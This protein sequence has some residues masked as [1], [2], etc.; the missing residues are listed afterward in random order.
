MRNASPP[1]STDGSADSAP[2]PVSGRLRPPGGTAD[3][4]GPLAALERNLRR[5]EFHSLEWPESEGLSH[6]HREVLELTIRHGLDSHGLG[7]VLGLGQSARSGQSQRPAHLGRSGRGARLLGDTVGSQGFGM[8]ADAWREL[9]RSLAA[10]AVA[11]ASTEHCAQLAELTSG[12]SGR[13][14]GT[15][16]APLTDHVDGCTRCQHYLHTVIGTPAAPTILPFITAPRALREIVLSE[17]RDPELAARQG[18]NHAA[19]ATR[20]KQFT[21]DGF[22]LASEPSP[23]RRHGVRR[24]TP[25]RAIAPETM[26]EAPQAATVRRPRDGSEEANPA[27]PFTEQGPAAVC[28]PQDALPRRVPG[29][30]RPRVNTRQP[31]TGTSSSPDRDRTYEA[32]DSSVVYRAPGSWAARVLPPESETRWRP[33]AADPPTSPSHGASDSGIDAR[34]RGRFISTPSGRFASRAPATACIESK[35]R[36]QHRSRPTRN[37]V[38]SA[39]TL[40]AVGTVAAATAALLG[41][42]SDSHSSPVTD[43]MPSR[44]A[45]GPSGDGLTVSVS[46]PPV[47]LTSS[48]A[49][50]SASRGRGHTDVGGTAA[51]GAA[52]NPGSTTPG[53]GTDPA[54]NAADFHVSV[55]QRAADPNS[56]AIVLRNS[57]STPIAWQ[58]V[59]QDS[60]ITL[61]QSSGTLA[62]GQSEAITATATSAA[63]AGEWTSTVTFSPGGAVVTLHGGYS[64][65]SSASTNPTSG[66]A[67]GSATPGAPSTGATASPAPGSSVHGPG[68]SAARSTYT[69]PTG[70]TSTGISSSA[71]A[72][73]SP[74][75]P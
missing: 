66:G 29:T 55:N 2:S 18:V 69:V 60:W 35:P 41:I 14:T 9:E 56:V 26:R 19:I 15:L 28:E 53:S 72:P 63:P 34:T 21:P 57:G 31:V 65:P 7:L 42:A 59:T 50:A 68:P 16:R 1:T 62:G 30:N 25:K 48:S 38:L 12:W 33:D 24:P 45:V 70:G 75:S 74:A 44:D 58:A 22:P 20:I 6:E 46:T 40:G 64:A 47:L 49:H 43:A 3:L 61:S 8:L 27:L 51:V 11:K 36:A 71:G 54:V 5:A 67:T 39:V 32:A 52:Q 10:V 4:S 23:P 73:P 17:L 13:L 37:A